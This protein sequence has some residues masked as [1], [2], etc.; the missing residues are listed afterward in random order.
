ML[1]DNSGRFIHQVFHYVQTIVKVCHISFSGMLSGLYHILFSDTA[2]EPIAGIYILTSSKHQITVY[3]F[4]DCCLL[5]RVFSVTQ[6]FFYK[7]ACF[8]IR[9]FPSSFFIDEGLIPEFYCHIIREIIIHNSAV[10]L[11]N[12]RHKN[13][14]GI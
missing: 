6:S 14:L 5:V 2:Y 4:I 8:F 13:L 1:E 3:Q 11:F 9:Y 7:L 12:I 10:H